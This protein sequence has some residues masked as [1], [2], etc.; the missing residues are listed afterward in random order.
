M[1]NLDEFKLAQELSIKHKSS[2]HVDHIVPLAGKYVCGLHCEENLQV[3][4]ESYNLHKR[5]YHES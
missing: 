2:F 1:F 4:P 5:N 3:V